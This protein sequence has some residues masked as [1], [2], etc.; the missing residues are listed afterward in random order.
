MLESAGASPPVLYAPPMRPHNCLLAIVARRN[1]G[2]PG[3][4][5]SPTEACC[6][7]PANAIDLEVNVTFNVQRQAERTRAEKPHDEQTQRDNPP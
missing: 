4:K 6:G 1:T 7:R 2:C 3:S 5:I